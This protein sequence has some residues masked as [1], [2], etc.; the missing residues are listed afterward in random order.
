MRWGREGLAGFQSQPL[1]ASAVWRLYGLGFGSALSACPKPTEDVRRES[2]P[3]ARQPPQACHHRGGQKLRRTVPGEPAL[4]R[5]MSPALAD[6]TWGT[7]ADP[8]VRE[9]GWR[10]PG[11]GTGQHS[12]TAA[13]LRLRG[14]ASRIWGSRWRDVN[15]PRAWPATSPAGR[16]FLL[17]Q[18]VSGEAESSRRSR[19]HGAVALPLGLPSPGIRC[20]RRGPPQP[21]SPR[22]RL[23]QRDAPLRAEP[24][25]PEPPS[26]GAC[27]PSWP[28]GQAFSRSLFLSSF[29]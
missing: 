20:G 1:W 17:P 11:E 22:L 25:S 14:K 2:C 4:G 9:T 5:M 16:V 19:A 28:P 27:F 26:L 13:R 29:P 24:S 12:V 23:A 15:T 21:S 8:A 7:E 18:H 3:W 6:W 10:A